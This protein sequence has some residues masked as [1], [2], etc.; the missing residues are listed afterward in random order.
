MVLIQSSTIRLGQ[1]MKCS[2]FF[3]HCFMLHIPIDIQ[4]TDFP[5]TVWY[6][7][8]FWI[9]LTWRLLLSH[10]KFSIS[11]H[12]KLTLRLLLSNG[13]SS[14]SI[15]LWNL[16]FY[17]LVWFSRGQWCRFGYFTSL[18]FLLALFCSNGAFTW[19][20]F[21]KVL[22]DFV[23]FTIQISYMVWGLGSFISFIA[24]GNSSIAIPL[25]NFLL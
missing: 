13:N 14:I 5:L 12:H 1:W 11:I 20:S 9:S 22:S 15:H 17:L 10:G 2:L 8:F 21:F 7:I 24:N 16:W 4:G 19:N 23:T 3:F 6:G 18:G 25:G